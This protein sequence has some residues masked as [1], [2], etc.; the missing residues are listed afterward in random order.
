MNMRDRAN[1]APLAVHAKQVA[2][3][4]R[5]SVYPEPFFT[6]MLKR[7]KRV[8]GDMFDLKNLG[9]NLTRLLPDGE[10]SVLH[11]HT[12]QD[13]FIYILEGSP[14]LVTDRGE[15]L[16]GPGDCAGFPAGGVAHQLVNRGSEDV[17][18]LEIGDRTAGDTAEY[19]GDDLQAELVN[20]A[21][22]FRHKDGSAY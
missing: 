18:Y 6:R 16:L 21:W 15:Q 12:R 4:V 22:L 19:P 8:L 2:P 10:S 5:P 11:R 13:E 17:L 1:S 20:G 3:R 9:V 7:E 14:T